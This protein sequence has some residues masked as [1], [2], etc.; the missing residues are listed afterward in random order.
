MRTNFDEIHFA[1]IINTNLISGIWSESDVSM[2]DGYIQE[3]GESKEV[4]EYKTDKEVVDTK[5]E[6]KTK[7]DS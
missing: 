5:T 1:T 2:A 3:C 6:I 4:E 7:L